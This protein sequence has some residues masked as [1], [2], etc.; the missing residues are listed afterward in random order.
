MGKMLNYGKRF[1]GGQIHTRGSPFTPGST[2]N[3]P[4]NVGWWSNQNR[5]NKLR[6]IMTIYD[7][8]DKAARVLGLSR[9]R[10]LKQWCHLKYED[11]KAGITDHGPREESSK[12]DSI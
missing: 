1:A 12:S 2:Y 6:H 3:A 4:G 5:N 9:S 10:C 11:I 7:D 8:P